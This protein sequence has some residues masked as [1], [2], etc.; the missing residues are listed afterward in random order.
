MTDYNAIYI[1]LLFHKK[2]LVYIKCEAII[3]VNKSFICVFYCDLQK[4]YFE[5]NK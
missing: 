3:S 1:T 2:Y 5:H 4:N